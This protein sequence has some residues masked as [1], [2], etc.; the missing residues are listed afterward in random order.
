[1]KHFITLVLAFIS[2]GTSIGQH[3]PGR[4]QV[5]LQAGTFHY[6]GDLNY[7]GQPDWAAYRSF[8]ANES[9]WALRAHLGRRLSPAWTWYLAGEYGYLLGAD[10]ARTWNGDIRSENPNLARALNVRTEIMSLQT[11][12]RYHLANDQWL[13]LDAGWDPYMEIGVGAIQFTPFGD[14]LDGEGN[15]YHYWADGSIRDR[16]ETAPNASESQIVERDRSY[17]TRLSDLNTN[18]EV[19]YPRQ[20]LI[21]PLGIGIRRRLGPGIWLNG[22]LRWQY[23]FSD[24]LDDASGAYPKG[25]DIPLENFAINPGGISTNSQER[26]NPDTKDSY[27][28]VGMGIEWELGKMGKRFEGLPIY[29]GFTAL[30]EQTLPMEHSLHDTVVLA[31]LPEISPETDISNSA[32]TETEVPSST[33]VPD[34]TIYIIPDLQIE[35]P[36]SDTIS[37]IPL[38]IVEQSRESLSA[39]NPLNTGNIQTI[40][41]PLSRDS[42]DSISLEEFPMTAIK[43][44]PQEEPVTLPQKTEDIPQTPLSAGS[45]QQT[46]GMADSLTRLRMEL[47]QLQVQQ[48]RIQRERVEADQAK[49][50]VQN[51]SMKS[52]LAAIEARQTAYNVNEAITRARQEQTYEADRA[53]DEILEKTEVPD[54]P[55]SA[56]QVDTL[57]ISTGQTDSLNHTSSTSDSLTV[58]QDSISKIPEKIRIQVGQTPPAANNP[59]TP[60]I[61]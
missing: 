3:L 38:P 6:L 22:N 17:E 4:W 21:I 46:N 60:P 29:T 19:D 55:V 7:Q 53:I 18:T 42:A 23:T 14:L 10:R 52:I 24:Y 57:P 15:I 49:L 32:A 20:T 37:Q 50:Q 44:I 40:E 9:P 27:L 25:S 33:P 30:P 12:L 35:L 31:S 13:D 54:M 45:R 8:D 48:E 51:D 5:G 36:K 47:L 1:M 58:P 11:G 43:I 41:V 34:T 59:G 39:T 16:A 61:G 28:F 26:G 2:A 56:T